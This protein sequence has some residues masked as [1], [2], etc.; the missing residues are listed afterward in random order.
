METPGFNKDTSYVQ[1]P[2]P[3]W[4]QIYLK[5]NALQFELDGLASFLE[6]LGIPPALVQKHATLHIMIIPRQRF[7]CAEKYLA[8]P[9]RK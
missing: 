3:T 5:L 4:S 6:P 8:P 7:Q 1:I 2:R 9:G